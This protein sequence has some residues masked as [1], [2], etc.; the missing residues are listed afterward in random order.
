[1]AECFFD[2]IEYVLLVLDFSGGK[3]CDFSCRIFVG[4]LKSIALMDLDLMELHQC[5][6][7]AMA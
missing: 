6:T 2:I 4:G 5:S 3:S 7:T 1:M